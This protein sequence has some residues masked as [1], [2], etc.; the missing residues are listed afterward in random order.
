[1]HSHYRPIGPSLEVA[2]TTN[3]FSQAL[4]RNDFVIATAAY[5]GWAKNFTNTVQLITFRQ[6]YVNT[7]NAW[8]SLACSPPS[9]AVSPPIEQ[10]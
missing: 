10:W 8:Q 3:N 4:C 5:T 9:I 2:P 1:M 7:R 6:D